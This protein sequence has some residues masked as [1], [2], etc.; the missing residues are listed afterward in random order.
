MTMTTR[1]SGCSHGNRHGAGLPWLACWLIAFG[2]LPVHAQTLETVLHNFAKESTPNGAAPVCAISDAAGN[3][4]GTTSGGGA[5][6]AGTVFKL[7]ASGNETVLYGFKGG[8]DGENPDAGIALDAAGN[9]YGTTNWGGATSSGIVFK[10]TPAGTETV[11]YSFTGGADGRT[12]YGGVIMDPAGNL[13]GT[14]WGGGATGAGTV[15]KVD[16]TGHETVLYSFTGGA[17]GGDP[18]AGLLLDSAGN[19]Y[20]TTVDG[21]LENGGVVFKVNPGGQETVLYT[22][23]SGADGFQPYTNVIMDPAGNLYG[24]ANGPGGTPGVVYRISTSG[25]FTVLYSFLGG[26]DGSDPGDVVRDAAGNLYGTTYFGGSANVGLVYKLDTGGNKTTLYDFPGG[27]GGA[28]PSASLFI[29]QA[30]NVYGTTLYGGIG[31]IGIVYKLD[32]GGHETPLYSFPYEGDGASPNGGLAIDAAGNLYGIAG[33]GGPSNAGI[34]YKIDPAGNETVLYSFTGGAD[35]GLPSANVTLDSAGNLYGTTSHGGTANAGTVFQLDAGGNETVLYSFQNGADGGYPQSG[36]VRDPAGNLYGTIAGGIG[37]VYKVSPAGQETV[38][39]TFM[40]GTDGFV[41][42]SGLVIDPAGNLYGTTQAG[43]PANAGTVY[44]VDAAGNETVLYSF[45]GGADG[46]G[47][48]TGLLRD[49]AG[50]LYGTTFSGGQNF[51]GTVFKLDPAGHLTVLYSSAFGIPNGTL[52]EDAAGNLYGTTGG[53]AI[54]DSGG[55]VFELTPAGNATVLYNFPF[56]GGPAAGVVRDPSGN[57]YGTS[58]DGGTNST[59]EVFKLGFASYTIC[60]QVTLLAAPLGGVTMTLSGTSSGSATTNAGGNYCFTGAAGGNYTVTPSDAGYT[61]SPVSYSVT[62]LGAN[63]TANFAAYPPD[64][65]ISGQVVTAEGATLGGV[66]ITLSGA[67]SGSTTTNSSGNYSLSVPAG[68]YTITPSLAHYTFTPPSQTFLSLNGNQT[69]NF[70][71]NP[72]GATYTISGQASLYGNG[73]GGAIVTLSGSQSGTVTANASGSY[74]FTL[75]AGGSYTVTPSLPGYYFYPYPASFTF[76]NLSANQ[77]ANFQAAIPS[78]FNRDGHPDVIWEEP[79]VGWAQVWYLGG[80][81]GAT[82]IAAADLTQA[83]PWNI[84]GI[85]DFNGDGNPDVVWQD[86]VSGAVQVWYLGGGGGVELIGAQDIALSNPWKVV[87]VADFNQD[88]HP[89]LLWQDPTSGFAQ[90]WYLGGPQGITLLGAANLDLTNP[91]QIVGTGD[92]NNDGFPDVLWQD[93]VSGTVQIWYMGGTTPGQ[94]GSQFQT[95][96]NLTGAMTTKV[97]AIADFNQDRHPDV[98]FQNPA[99]GAATIYFYTGA[100]GT[101]PNGTAILS[102][103]NPWYIAGPH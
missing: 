37:L 67:G 17:D 68:T 87:S 89:D 90:I 95:A 61:F 30:G 57:L 49:A 5:S 42:E 53:L 103:G 9:I 97:V 77:T 21:G 51:L 72:V 18:M 83:N 66:T 6:S 63:Q 65:I 55:V 8:T 50:N 99:T 41:P 16:A 40:G 36:L 82:L 7:D 11:L 78:D 52:V 75:P 4:Y 15:F 10:V 38:L 59:G 35:G 69:A 47:P 73:L 96:L 101:T 71:A 60:G 93:P 80:S 13:Y 58:P 62:N 56:W 43:G 31:N 86:P 85:A 102:S 88:G 46:F 12:P 79:L 20:G 34:V 39:H 27:V 23:Q 14:T 29:D 1:D 32:S 70:T 48:A 22:F 98:V 19:L 84:V 64:Y 45:T 33:N 44:E 81:Q 92:F 24:T 100:T 28:Q 54:T 76:G 74:T 91:W 3:L 26:A 2:V 25:H 94:Q